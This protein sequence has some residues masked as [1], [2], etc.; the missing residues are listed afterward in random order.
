MRIGMIIFTIMLSFIGLSQQ[1]AQYSQWAFHQFSFNPAHA[2]IQP[3]VDIHTAY[4]AQWVGFGGAPNSGFATISIP[5]T[6]LRKKYLNTR[7]GLGARFET[8]KLGN[9][10]SNRINLAY[11]AHFNFNQNDRLSMGLYGGVVQFSFDPTNATTSVPDPEVLRQANVVKPDFTAGFWYNSLNYY[12]GLT[13]QNLTRSMWTGIGETS[14][15]RFHVNLVGGFKFKVNESNSLMP[16]MI[17]R[18]PP[19]GPI[20]YDLNL[21]FDYSNVFGIGAGYRNSDALIAFVSFKIR[22]QF[23]IMY[24]FDYT[25]SGIQKVSSNTHELSFK[26]STCKN[27]QSGTTGCPLFQ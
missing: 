26:F 6:Q 23:M 1:L 2:G 5:V 4:R 3:C 14:R 13:L 19:K 10:A 7:H 11:A 24:S 22:D 12:G 27:R 8:D 15:H 17:V 21:H 18:V 25:I 16:H 20:S 9:F